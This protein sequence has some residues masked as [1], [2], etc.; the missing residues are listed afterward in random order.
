MNPTSPRLADVDATFRRIPDAETAARYRAEGW[1]GDVTLADRI[2]ELAATRPEDTAFITGHGR[3]SWRRYE[4]DSARLATALARLGL[5]PG[6]RLGIRATDGATVHTAFLAA[7]KAGLTA[8]G[9]GA[10]AGRREI[11]HLLAST[12][13]SALLTLDD[14]RDDDLDT[15][16]LRRAAPRLRHRIVVPVL[17]A[18]GAPLASFDGDPLDLAGVEAED[19]S[20]RRIGPDDL[21]MVNSTSGTTGLPK[22]VMHTQNRW[23]YFHQRAVAHGRLVPE[24]VFLGGVPAPFGFGLWTAHFTPTL[25]GVPTVVLERFT[26]DAMIE[27]IERERVTVLCCVSTQFIMML[28]S[29]RLADHDLSSLRVMF[30]GGEMVPYEQARSFEARTGAQ[31]LQFFGSNE[32]GL[33]SGTKTTD[34]QDQRLRTAGQVVPEMNVRLFDDGRDV[35]DAGRGQPGGRGPAACM[36]YLGDPTANAELFTP[37]GWMLMGDIVTVDAHG[38]LR[39]IGRKSDF[40][41]R[42]GKNISAAQVE[43]AASSHPAVA[44]AAAVPVPDPVFGERV[45]L[46][47]E[48][49]EGATLTLA[50]LTG[51]MLAQGTSKELLPERLVVLDE[52]PRS[53][54]GK[55]AK[56]ELKTALAE[57]AE[58]DATP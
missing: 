53:S 20:A 26:A 30:T 41:I 47:V 45:C 12:G 1:W 38:Y 14:G 10:R 23:I 58:G 50:E 4:D 15:E 46:F 49:A 27:A 36:G 28:S 40:I 34:T 52:L 57:G 54:G 13:A 42:G 44:L 37:D 22:C 3:Y 2:A 51:H 35:T 11:E 18:G 21:F 16:E 32:T 25:L 8:V 6:E 48:L 19:L 31:V 55:I 17:E 9:I 56:G 7:E 39:V 5:E 24:D 29:P 43:D 33:F